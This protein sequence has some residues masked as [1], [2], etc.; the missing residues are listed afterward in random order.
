MING[1]NKGNAYERRLRKEFIDMGWTKCQTARYAS[2]MVDDSKVD[3]C[4][5]D[6]FNIQAKAIENSVNYIKLLPQMPSDCNYNI[7]IHKRD[8]KEYAIMEKSTL[9]ALIKLLVKNQI[10]KP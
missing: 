6:P 1:R 9:Y 10:I 4:F 7:I 5:V 8:R 2:K 3:L